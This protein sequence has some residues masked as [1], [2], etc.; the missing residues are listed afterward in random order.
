MYIYIYIHTHTYIYIISTFTAI[1]CIE[2]VAHSNWAAP[3]IVVPK[4]DDC[5]RVCGDYK[6][7]INSTLVVDKYSL[8]KPED[9]MAQWTKVLQTCFKPCLSTYSVNTILK[10]FWNGYKKWVDS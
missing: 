8:L 7:T 9:L 1:G 3:I 10:R 2:K 6:V 4:G 5:L